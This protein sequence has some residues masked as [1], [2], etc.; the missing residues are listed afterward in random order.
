MSKFFRVRL[1]GLASRH[2]CKQYFAQLARDVLVASFVFYCSFCCLFTSLIL[3]SVRCAV[4][5]FVNISSVSSVSSSNTH[6][7]VV[8]VHVCFFFAHIIF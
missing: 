8:V 7:M 6:R 3:L 5:A 1:T 2:Y 4:F